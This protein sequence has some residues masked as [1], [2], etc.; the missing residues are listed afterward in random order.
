MLEVDQLVFDF[1]ELENLE[2]ELVVVTCVLT[3]GVL[4]TGWRVLMMAWG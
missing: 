3:M 2:H 1:F 4:K